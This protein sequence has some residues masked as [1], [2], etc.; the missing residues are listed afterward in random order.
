MDSMHEADLINRARTGD[1]VAWDRL[2]RQHKASVESWCWQMTH[3]H[4]DA[5]DLSQEVFTRLFLHLTGFRGRA[6]LRTWLYR[7]TLNCVLMC[8]R[9]ARHRQILLDRGVT[10]GNSLLT[11]S[12][13]VS[14]FT[15][16]PNVEALIVQQAIQKLPTQ[17]RAVLLL[18][19]VSGL[20]H[21][22]IGR[23]LNLTI[24]N[25]KFSLRKARLE[26]RDNLR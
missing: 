14:R 25:S 18:H 19:E 2:Y 11:L 4:A 16:T 17:K 20:S 13:G 9:K 8:K 1:A 6:K 24:E 21:R 23:K 12:T 3:N 10:S 5:E 7:I 15:S 26:L 22:E